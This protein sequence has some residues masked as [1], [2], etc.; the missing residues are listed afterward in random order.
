MKQRA[1][2]LGVCC[3]S[4][5]KSSS[6]WHVLSMSNSMPKTPHCFRLIFRILGPL[7]LGPN[8]LFRFFSPIAS[9]IPPS[10]YLP[11]PPTASWSF[12]P[13]HL[14]NA[15]PWP[16]FPPLLHLPVTPSITAPT[17]PPPPPI[18]LSRLNSTFSPMT[19]ATP[20]PYWCSTCAPPISQ[21]RV[22][23]YYCHS[24]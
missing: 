5:L 8:C 11:L 2:H 16:G 22:G 6:T 10:T 24:T 1:F 13:S 20:L 3:I 7:W 14:T 12:D 18:H 15:V 4:V 23:V 19:T 17:P 9:S 21:W